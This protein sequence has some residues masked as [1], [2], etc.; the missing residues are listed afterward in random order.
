MGVSLGEGGRQSGEGQGAWSRCFSHNSCVAVEPSCVLAKCP[1]CTHRGTKPH[2]TY[3]LRIKPMVEYLNSQG[4]M[5]HYSY[6][7]ERFLFNTVCTTIYV[8]VY[9]C[10]HPNLLALAY[11]LITV[12]GMFSLF[13]S[14][15][16]VNERQKA[17]QKLPFPPPCLSGG[18]D[19]SR[20][21]KTN[22]PLRNLCFPWGCS[23]T[24]TYQS[25]YI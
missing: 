1:D 12:P 10:V 21:Y 16:L 24:R 20:G 15:L 7:T 18:N 6:L 13:L 2:I 9:L 23:C 19:H 3:N 5:T 25:K 17:S 11:I 14:P 8:C 4:F 22:S